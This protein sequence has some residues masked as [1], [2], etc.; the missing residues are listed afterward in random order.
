MPKAFGKDVPN[1][2]LIGA[3]ACAAM[4]A[5]NQFMGGSAA[6]APMTKRK[7]PAKASTA[8]SLYTKEDSTAKFAVY[9]EPVKNAFQPV[10]T[11][12]APHVQ[13]NGGINSVVT[14]GE[15]NWFYTGN[16]EVNGRAQ[17]LLENTASG[18]SVYLAKG[19]KFKGNATVVDITPEQVVFEAPTGR[20][21]AKLNDPT[22]LKRAPGVG[23]M[24]S[25]APMNPANGL[26][27]PIGGNP[28]ATLPG[29]I[30]PNT[31]QPMMAPMNGFP[32][33]TDSNQGNGRRRGGRGRGGFGG[34]GFGN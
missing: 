10:L 33:Q 2:M 21:V 8:S 17:A 14:G 6:P 5:Y 18:Q 1:W 9:T 7:A 4:L 22:E 24:G 31:G 20:V 26:V 3:A 12:T 30:D 25:V 13:A 34:G 11:S 29:A 19:E 28:M 27:G 23:A 15:G 16:I 32:A